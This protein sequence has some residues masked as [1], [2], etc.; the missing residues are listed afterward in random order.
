[1]RDVILFRPP[2]LSPDESESKCSLNPVGNEVYF[3]VGDLFRKACPDE[4]TCDEMETLE[5]KYVLTILFV[6]CFRQPM[7]WWADL[8]ER[9]QRV[10]VAKLPFGGITVKFS[11]LVP[12]IG[13]DSFWNS[14]L[15]R[16]SKCKIHDYTAA[17]DDDEKD[18]L[19]QRLLRG[20]PM[21]ALDE[22]V[23]RKRW[24]RSE[25]AVGICSTH[26]EALERNAKICSWSVQSG[27]GKIH[28]FLRPGAPVLVTGGD[29]EGQFGVVVD[30][31]GEESGPIYRYTTVFGVM[32]DDTVQEI[33]GLFLLCAY[34]LCIEDTVGVSFCVKKRTL[35]APYYSK[36][37][38]YQMSLHYES[39]NPTRDHLL[40]VLARVPSRVY[41]T[42][43][44]HE[45]K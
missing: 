6:E 19:C 41:F 13:K 8:N 38:P 22:G 7:S 10:H 5:Y 23:I 16:L 34:F 17:S 35:P 37:A 12:S 30:V 31:R 44:H 24:S 18:D 11:G 2:T 33:L 21:T 36:R 20:L 1:M 42:T 29:F 43:P 25:F 14:A 27:T 28:T 26:D 32:I 39:I 9:L 4:Y 45:F 3:G 15:Y 40:H